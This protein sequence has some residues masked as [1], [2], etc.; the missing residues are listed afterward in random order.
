MIPFP[1]AWV[2]I[3]LSIFPALCAHRPS[4]LPIEWLGR[5]IKKT[6]LFTYLRSPSSLAVPSMPLSL[7]FADNLLQVM[8]CILW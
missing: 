6:S 1:L 7:Y 2:P 4:L 8:L 5:T 3:D